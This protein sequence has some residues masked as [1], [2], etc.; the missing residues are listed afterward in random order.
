MKIGNINISKGAALSPMAGATD[1]AM[2]HLCAKHGAVYTVSEMVSVKAISMGDKKSPRM[3]LGGG[4]DAPYGIQLFGNDPQDFAT[5]INIIN[6]LSITYDF[7]DINMGCPAPKI[8][9]NGSGSALLKTP[10]IAQAIAKAAVDASNVPVTVKLRIGWDDATLTGLEVAQKCEAQGVSAVA[11]HARTRAEMYNLG[12]HYDEVKKIKH[13]L[14]IPVIANGDII[15][16]ESAYAALEQTDCD[17]LL[18][19][20]GAMGN[21]WLFGEISAAFNDAKMPLPPTLHTRL[22]TMKQHIKEMCDNKGEGVAMNEARSHT[23]WYMHGLKGAA[24]LRRECCSLSHFQDIDHL[25]DLVY[26]LQ[27]D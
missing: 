9:N 3:L 1:K 11:V 18:I 17:G 16:V 23:A 27:K 6:Q 4:G 7:I 22:S 15:S 25:I 19:G 13:A 5:A 8:T 21:P 12:V 20:R 26:R 10:D 14:R 24:Q 2:R